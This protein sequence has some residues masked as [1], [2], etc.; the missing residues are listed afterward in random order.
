[1][2]RVSCVYILPQHSVKWLAYQARHKKVLIDSSTGIHF[3]SSLFLKSSVWNFVQFKQN[4]FHKKVFKSRKTL[5]RRRGSAISHRL[6][7]TISTP[8]IMLIF[9]ASTPN[10]NLQD[11][12]KNLQNAPFGFYDIASQV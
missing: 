11:I 6:I 1:M 4:P 5:S 8:S 10:S 9:L 3:K 12:K 7:R 2:K